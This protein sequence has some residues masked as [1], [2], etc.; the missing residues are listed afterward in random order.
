MLSIEVDATEARRFGPWLRFACLPTPASLEDFDHY[1]APNL[2]RTLIAELGATP[3]SPR[4]CSTGC[5]TGRGLK[6][7][8]VTPLVSGPPRAENLRNATA[9][10]RVRRR[11]GIH[12]E[13][14]VVWRDV[15]ETA[16]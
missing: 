8:T 13:P 7:T 15:H 1:A 6:T 9:A 2:D 16:V 14:C 5:C 12:L 4:P 10:T 3:P 11:V